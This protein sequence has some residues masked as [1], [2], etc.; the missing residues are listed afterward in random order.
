MMVNLITKRSFIRFF[1]TKKCVPGGTLRDVC[2]GTSFAPGI[3]TL[4][5]LVTIANFGGPVQYMYVHEFATDS[6]IS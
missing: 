6:H 3:S 1:F 5:F 4:I 2:Q